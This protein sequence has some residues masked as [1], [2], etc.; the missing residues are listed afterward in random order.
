MRRG[1]RNAIV[2]VLAALLVAAARAAAPPE[3]LPQDIAAAWTKAGAQ[4][5]WFRFDEF[6]HFE[7]VAG[8]EGESGDVPAFGVA[9]WPVGKLTPLPAP[10]VP[11][12]LDLNGTKVTNPGL[13][14]L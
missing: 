7:F 1:R 6:G 12:G 3:P 10:T 9:H 14:E 4:V 11:F 5:G 8:Q 2:A 13:R